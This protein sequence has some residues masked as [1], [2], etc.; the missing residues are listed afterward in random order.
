MATIICIYW[1]YRMLLNIFFR[2]FSNT[3]KDNI[4]PL[5]QVGSLSDTVTVT[6]SKQTA[7]NQFNWFFQSMELSSKATIVGSD[8]VSCQHNS[9]LSPGVR[10]LDHN[11][12]SD[13]LQ[14]RL[15]T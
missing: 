11:P 9:A 13:H 5:V 6:V 1:Y 7:F 3:T 12:A 10:P 14:S 15:L 8:S 4:T 2:N